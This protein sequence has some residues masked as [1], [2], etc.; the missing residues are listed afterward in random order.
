MPKKIKNLSLAFLKLEASKKLLFGILAM[1]SF[2]TIYTMIATTINPELG[3]SLVEIF[4]VTV[5][6]YLLEI[7]AYSIKAW[8]EN[9]KKYSVVQ[10][11]SEETTPTD[12]VG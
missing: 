5:N 1:F 12:T 3:P 8:S 2:Q 9:T 7:P 10:T 4:K 6:V 11:V